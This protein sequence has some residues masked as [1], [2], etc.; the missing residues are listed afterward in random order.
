MNI[1][2]TLNKQMW[3]YVY[4]MFG[5]KNN[6]TIFEGI[7]KV[8]DISVTWNVHGIKISLVFV[9]LLSDREKCPRR[10]TVNE[11]QW[12]RCAL[13]KNGYFKN[14]VPTHQDLWFSIA[15]VQMNMV[16]RTLG[17]LWILAFPV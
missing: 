16:N 17:M 4:V 6:Y 2:E 7:V 14:Y 10:M 12:W 15:E 8:Y 13:V 9:D 11:L 1:Q 5:R 3:V